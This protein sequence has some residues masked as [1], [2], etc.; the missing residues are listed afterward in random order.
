MVF[1]LG[2]VPAMAADDSSEGYAV[3]FG[4]MPAGEFTYVES[5][6]SVEAG[7]GAAQV[8]FIYG[9]KEGNL[10]WAMDVN[11]TVQSGADTITGDMLTFFN[12]LYYQSRPL[13]DWL[14]SN[15]RDNEGYEANLD[16]QLIL[17]IDENGKL[18]GINAN[19][20]TCNVVALLS[21]DMT[22]PTLT[23]KGATRGQP[24]LLQS[25]VTL[26][27]S[28]NCILTTG[29]GN[30][31]IDSMELGA[32]EEGIG[33]TSSKIGGD[34]FI[35]GT[36]KVDGIVK[37]TARYGNIQ[38]IQ[39]TAVATIE[40]N[41]QDIIVGGANFGRVRRTLNLISNGGDIIIGQ[42]V[43]TD[44][45]RGAQLKDLSTGSLSL[46]T[47]GVLNAG[48]GDVIIG[49]NDYRVVNI[50]KV[51]DIIAN[52][53]T[54]KP[55]N[56]G[57]SVTNVSTS[58]GNITAAGN[59]EIEVGSINANGTSNESIGNITAGGD[60]KVTAG[61]ING[62]VG[63]IAAAGKADVTI[64]SL[65]GIGEITGSEV[66]KNIGEKKEG[67]DI[68]A[69]PVSAAV[70][71]NGE[72][73]EFDA[74]TI[75]G[76]NYFKIRDIALQLA[77]TSA[78]FGL[79]WHD[80]IDGVVTVTT[81]RDY[82]ANGTEMAAKGTAVAN[83]VAAKLSFYVDSV[84]V[85]VEAYT[86]NGGIYF[87]IDDLAS[88]LGFNADVTSSAIAITT[89]EEAKPF[90]DIPAGK[91]VYTDSL[92]DYGVA[93]GSGLAA[94][95]FRYDMT[96]DQLIW[97][98]DVDGEV[99]V[100][101]ATLAGAALDF[102]NEVY[103]SDVPVTDWLQGY[104]KDTE[105]Y[106]GE[107]AGNL[108]LTFA[109]NGLISA[110]NVSSPKTRVTTVLSTDIVDDL[111]VVSG[112]TRSKPFLQSCITMVGEVNGLSLTKQGDVILDELTIGCDEE[113]VGLYGSKIGGD[114][115]VAGVVQING[116]I[117][118]NSKMGVITALESE[119]G[120]LETLGQE[121]VING[122]SN[123]GRA[124][125]ELNI[126]SNGGDIK[127]G[128]EVSTDQTRGGIIKNPTSPNILTI[129]TSGRIDAGADG[130]VIIGT[131]TRENYGVEIDRIDYING[132]N[133][134][135][136]PYN[137]GVAGNVVTSIGDIQAA[138]S[139]DIE[140]GIINTGG[141]VT[142]SFSSSDG[143]VE[144]VIEI[145]PKNVDTSGTVLGDMYAANG[146]IKIRATKVYGN[147]GTFTA[148][149]GT[150]DVEFEQI[151][152]TGKES[153]V[154][155]DG[156]YIYCVDGVEDYSKTG[157]VTID[158]AA[159]FINAGKVD[160]N[161]NGLIADPDS[162]D[163]YYCAEGIV[164]KVTQLVEYDGEWFY[165]TD[166]CLDTEFAGLVEYDG[167]LFVVAAGQIKDV[168][169]LWQNE[170]TFGGD[171]TWYFFSLGQAQTQYTGLALYDGTWFYVQNGVFNPEFS[172]S[173][174][175]DET[176]VHIKDGVMVD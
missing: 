15:S 141:V 115:F 125:R 21:K 130:D 3:Q 146:N 49:T 63:N 102:F 112:S 42:D 135:I 56:N 169:G 116:S 89:E 20:G 117:Q 100:G 93:A 137:Y 162:T 52:N 60:V 69:T 62:T 2:I 165:V 16:G 32:N 95:E 175:Y 12:E 4:T 41:G 67:I 73:V 126:L 68:L 19:D 161:A 84:A 123:T 156:E 103:L 171:G 143:T 104:P 122:G 167:G 113:G 150:V 46:S 81:G 13:Y 44:Y 139:I 80:T 38:P 173:I 170:E 138:E 131:D 172:G 55:T 94:I 22:A 163:W 72:A 59:V 53:V 119:P 127:I 128:T 136:K 158:D 153:L 58:I 87:K 110:I 65:T 97:A 106:A 114:T 37:W 132:K 118:W 166:G 50:D 75:E 129:S 10:V 92:A 77:D 174:V 27:G 176:I 29:Q 134:I 83:A 159:F 18:S 149:N 155:N 43:S 124:Q 24:N 54:I 91:Y 101:T 151:I 5:A 30:V 11:G 109:E 99:Q 88:V 51:G 142:S 82:T 9:Q 148:P 28:A 164:Q 105:G 160:T 85:S 23:V 144:H 96:V 133:V 1:T 140:V 57:T 76:S 111:L 157:F 61:D 26:M 98:V 40:T 17:T 168:N 147:V 33:L 79:D 120:T 6:P 121:I 145:D 8:Q 90:G 35:T 66:N 78:K 86:V 45:G 70:T 14:A 34:V 71:V 108:E 47:S 74:Y 152:D 39:E 154:E 48:T 7:S 31:V 64:A 36:V 107:V 25:S